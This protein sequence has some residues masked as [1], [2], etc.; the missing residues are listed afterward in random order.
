MSPQHLTRT[1]TS[2]LLTAA[3]PLRACGNWDSSDW[4]LLQIW[5]RL[6][7]LFRGLANCWTKEELRDLCSMKLL[8]QAQVDAAASLKKETF[9]MQ[10]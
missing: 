9:S 1:L 3:I 7:R 4:V 8:T 10:K 5:K 2:T 6:T